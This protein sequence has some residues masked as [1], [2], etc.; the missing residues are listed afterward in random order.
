MSDE[1]LVNEIRGIV[2]NVVKETLQEMFAEF[3]NT[4]EKSMSNK[5]NVMSNSFL[6]ISKMLEDSGV[7]SANIDKDKLSWQT[8][9][10]NIIY[11]LIQINKTEFPTCNSVIKAIYIKM[12]NVY[13]IV[14]DQLRKEYRDRYGLD[15]YPNALEAVADD[16]VARKVFESILR[17]LFPDNYW[18]YKVGVV[19]DTYTRE[20]A[21]TQ[22]DIVRSI[23]KPLAEKYDDKSKG[24]NRTFRIVYQKMDCAWS[25]LQTR[26]KKNNNL[27]TTPQKL[28]IVINNPRVF[29]EFK[30]CVRELL[31][32]VN[33]K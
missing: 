32:E 15:Y 11:E 29:R 17:D 33:D 21:Q 23:I 6:Y 7:M 1:K 12:R 18:S 20:P 14:L 26:Y 10:Q 30:K 25:N 19:D 5:M 24:Y 27:K 2:N 9:M 31:D 3:E 16:E 13:G 8:D 4:F 22:E 28:T